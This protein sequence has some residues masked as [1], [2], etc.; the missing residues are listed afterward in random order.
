MTAADLLNFKRPGT[1]EGW[2]FRRGLR[3]SVAAMNRAWWWMV[4]A[5]LIASAGCGKDSKCETVADNLAK[6]AEKD[7]KSVSAGDKAQL[8]QKCKEEDWSEEART[9]LVAAKATADTMSCFAI[10]GGASRYATKSKTSEA[11][12]LVKKMYDGARAF[13]MD[14]PVARDSI[15]PQ[16]PQFPKVS[17]GP[18]PPLG[19]CCKQGGMCQ[20]KASLWADETWVQLLFSV[21]DPH[22]Y[23]Y[24]YEVI[25]PASKFVVRAFGDLDC[26]GT[27]STFELVGEV[28]PANPDGPSGN[29]S[30][31][32]TNEL[33]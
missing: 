2:F 22:Y 31:R 27:Y 33:E 23:S 16:P 13:Y 29:A 18:T 8:A 11:R 12:M 14:G 20:P 32:M 15:A 4:V 30:I 5:A 24:Q 3:D 21:D 1:H 7:G 17:V 25:D 19:E 10:A 6:L 9:C 26:D 28:T